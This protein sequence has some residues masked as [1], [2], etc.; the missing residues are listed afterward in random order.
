MKEREFSKEEVIFRQGEEGN[1]FFRIM[2]GCVG[3]FGSYQE[4]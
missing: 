1:A 2:E 4:P 3:I